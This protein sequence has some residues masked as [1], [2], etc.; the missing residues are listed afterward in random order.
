MLGR[1]DTNGFILVAPKLF[2]LP[3]GSENGCC[4]LIA[5][6]GFCCAFGCLASCSDSIDFTAILAFV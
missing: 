2:E 6:I 3:L 1:E 4:C 5:V